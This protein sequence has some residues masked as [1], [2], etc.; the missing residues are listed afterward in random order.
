[1]KEIVTDKY[2]MKVASFFNNIRM[3]CP[4]CHSAENGLPTTKCSIYNLW[5]L[6]SEGSFKVAI[7]KLI[8]KN[9]SSELLR[10]SKDD[11]DIVDSLGFIY[12][13]ISICDKIHTDNRAINSS[14]S[15]PPNTQIYF[16]LYTA[17][18]E[19]NTTLSKI[20]YTNRNNKVYTI[21]VSEP[22]NEFV[23]S[24]EKLR[25]ENYKLSDEFQKL[26]EEEKTCEERMNALRERMN[27]ANEDK[28][29]AA[30]YR[31]E[32]DD[33][34]LYIISEEKEKRLTFSRRFDLNKSNYNWVNVGEPLIYLYLDEDNSSSFW[35][36]K[37][38]IDS[39]TTG[40]FEFDKKRFIAY[41]E[42]ICKIRKYSPE[43]K[44][45]VFREFEK[46]AIKESLLKKEQKKKLE[47][48]ALDELIEEGLIFNTYIDK[49]GNRNKISNETA[50]AV[51][52]R[53]GGK[54]CNCGSKENLEFDHIIPVSKGGATTFQNLQLLCKPCNIRKSNKIG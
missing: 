6:V 3:L 25:I 34:Y 33:E 31:T 43:Q 5:Q 13:P 53:D 29:P 47:R 46:E 35:V 2:I 4:E 45:E 9:I 10:I 48:E 54:C 8:I 30:Q 50:N 28:K 51:W 42:V 52:N 49:M 15:L 21:K 40:I 12:K 19:A 26:Q 23:S 27:S 22:D 18:F 37:C 39:P 1:M 32:D 44:A 17:P 7:T 20:Y 38:E 41:N 24:E 11:F 14:Y 36:A 16:N